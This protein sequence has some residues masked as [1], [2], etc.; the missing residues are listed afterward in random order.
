MTTH[1]DIQG[2]F[3]LWAQPTNRGIFDPKCPSELTLCCMPSK[4]DLAMHQNFP[5]HRHHGH[6]DLHHQRLPPDWNLNT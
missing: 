3:H 2:K 4:K 5:V 1:C 6:H